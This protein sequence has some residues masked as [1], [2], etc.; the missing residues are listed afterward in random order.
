M[1]LCIE[2]VIPTDTEKSYNI[3]SNLEYRLFNKTVRRIT[4]TLTF[5]GFNYGNR[6]VISTFISVSCLSGIFNTYI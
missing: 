1:Y 2:Q 6:F 5:F 3:L 4:F